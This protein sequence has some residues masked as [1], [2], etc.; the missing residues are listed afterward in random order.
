MKRIIT[1]TVLL[2]LPLISSTSYAHGWYAEAM[3]NWVLNTAIPQHNEY[4]SDISTLETQ[5]ADQAALI[6]S[7]QADLAATNAY[8]QDLQTYV[9]VDDTTDPGRPAV[10]VSGANLQVVNGLSNT[11]TT[12]GVGN[13]LVGYDENMDFLCL[14]GTE[15]E[16]IFDETTCNN[17]GGLWWPLFAVKTGSHNVIVGER[18][19]YESYSG[20]VS[21]TANYSRSQGASILGGA[22][23]TVSGN[24]GSIAGGLQNLV[25]GKRSS[26]AGGIGNNIQSGGNAASIS[27]GNNNS[28][29]D[30]ASTVGGGQNRSATG[31]SDWVAGSLLEDF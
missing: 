18:H 31:A 3:W 12:N 27:G 26:I 21:G 6:A 17:G 16:N 14:G 1:L 7:L 29:T 24:W 8:V 15:M 11:R 28:A 4:N 19:T 10:I 13:I 2:L 30:S 20:F 25:E 9:N 22:Y 23:N 5:L